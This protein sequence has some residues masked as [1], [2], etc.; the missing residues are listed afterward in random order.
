[1]NFL[2]K[3]GLTIL[4]VIGILS[5]MAPLIG[6]AVPSAAPAFDAILRIG[7]V[8][9]IVEQ[10]FVAAFGSGVKMGSDKLKA[11]VPFVAQLI[12]QSELMV[13]KKVKD[14]AG[15]IASVEKI[16]SGF[17]DLLNSIEEK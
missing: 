2:K 7:Q 12:Q 11:A 17:A 10:M 15:F 9:V 3:A 1:M 13:G 5:G 8:I 6:Q 4:K 14:E 16:T